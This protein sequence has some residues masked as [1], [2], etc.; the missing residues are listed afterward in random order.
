MATFMDQY[1]C[2][3][4]KP[5]IKYDLVK[6]KKKRNESIKYFGAKWNEKATE[7]VPSLDALEKGRMFIKALD[8]RYYQALFLGRTFDELVDHAEEVERSFEEGLLFWLDNDEGRLRSNTSWH[9][10]EKW[11]W[12]EEGRRGVINFA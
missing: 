12:E 4:K 3:C 2:L 5:T 6:M 8:G 1:G 7:I 10:L 11:Q 9:C